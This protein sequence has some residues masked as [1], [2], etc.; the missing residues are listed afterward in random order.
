MWQSL[1]ADGEMLGNHAELLIPAFVVTQH[2]SFLLMFRLARVICLESECG[3]VFSQVMNGT[4]FSR[5]FHCVLLSINSTYDHVLENLVRTGRVRVELKHSS[6]AVIT[7]VEFRDIA[8]KVLR[9]YKFST[10]VDSLVTI[11]TQY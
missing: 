5:L 4:Y 7:V 9:D 8:A 3:D 10:W 6:Q 1:A 11:R 2:Y